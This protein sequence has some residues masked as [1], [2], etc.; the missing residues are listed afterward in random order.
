VVKALRYSRKVLG[1]IPGGVT[2]DISVASDNSMCPGSIQPLKMSTR[3]LLGKDGRCVRLK[4]YHI[5]VTMSRNLEALTSQNTL[6]P[7]G[8][9]ECVAVAQK[10]YRGIRVVQQTPAAQENPRSTCLHPRRLN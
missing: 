10:T 7:I 6:G 2:G 1:S 8:P 3:I 4:T 9:I 5:Q